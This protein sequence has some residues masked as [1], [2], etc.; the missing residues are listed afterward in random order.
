[1]AGVFDAENAPGVEPSKI[2]VGDF[3][4]WKRSDLSSDYPT[5]SHSLTYVLTRN[6]GG[7]AGKIDI[8]AIEVSGEYVV[9]LGSST[10]SAYTKGGYRWEAYI[11]ETS[12]SNR[13]RVDFGTI[14]IV[15]NFGS[16]TADPRS[17]A[18]I[19]L[20][21]IES[22]LENR[23][24]SD[25]DNYTINNRSIGKIPV[26]ELREWREYYLGEVRREQDKLR[27]ERGEATRAHLQV[28]FK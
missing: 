7:T 21:K 8:T 6:D 18:E 20:A 28:R 26:T 22:V 10:T 3:T 17:H 4:Q 13:V 27:R 2:V 5:A 15:Q 25:V 1:M 12:S 14:E 23:A 9:T 11:T 19:M 24:D 16:D